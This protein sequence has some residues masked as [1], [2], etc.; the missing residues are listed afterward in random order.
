LTVSAH[1]G[2]MASKLLSQGPSAAALT[3]SLPGPLEFVSIHQLKA[4]LQQAARVAILHRP[5]D[6][7]ASSASKH[8]EHA[9]PAAATKGKHLPG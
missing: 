2:G 4:W 5:I 1:G 7:T 6:C 3:A 9:L 8:K